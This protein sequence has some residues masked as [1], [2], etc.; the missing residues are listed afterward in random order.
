MDEIDGAGQILLLE[1]VGIASR[2]LQH[3]CRPCVRRSQCWRPEE[4][5]KVSTH[6]R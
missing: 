4:G 6:R 2:E 1:L 3:V 5:T